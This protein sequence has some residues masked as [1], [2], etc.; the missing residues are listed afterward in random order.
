MDYDFAARFGELCRDAG[1]VALGTRADRRLHGSRRARQEAQHGRRDARPFRRHREGRRR[2][3]R[4]LPPGLPARAHARGR[5]STRC[6]SNSASCARGWRRRT[7]RV[8]FG[9]EVMGRVRELGTVGRRRRDLAPAR[10]GPPRPRLRAHA[11]DLGRG[12]SRA[13]SRSPRRSRRRTRSSSAGAPFHIHFSD[14]QFANRNETKHLPYGEGTLRA[15][16]LAGGARAVRRPAT[17][18]SESPDEAS[19]QAIQSVLKGR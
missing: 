10:L 1:I 5:R 4:R 18:I 17:V 15:D 3:G 13:S 6:A 19:S 16:P 11:R 7:A 8:P 14:I 2:R 12:A 9:I